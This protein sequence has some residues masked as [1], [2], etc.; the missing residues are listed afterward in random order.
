[1]KLDFS[2]PAPQ[3]QTLEETQQIINALWA[4][5]AELQAKVADLEEKLNTNSKNSSKPP[6]I[7]SFKAKKKRNSMAQG[8]AKH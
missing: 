8:K 2:K 7:D 5:V 3:A 6:S 4:I 1:M